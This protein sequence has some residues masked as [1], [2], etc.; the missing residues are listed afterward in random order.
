[1]TMTVPA[2]AINLDPICVHGL[3]TMGPQPLNESVER[4]IC[5]EMVR[6]DSA[7]HFSRAAPVHG[8]VQQTF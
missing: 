6:N 8:R 4:L 5:V 2:E 1:M 7:V 3:L